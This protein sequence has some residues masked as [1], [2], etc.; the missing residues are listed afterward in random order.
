[1]EE[2]TYL[3]RLSM[4]TPFVKK[5]NTSMRKAITPNEM[6][7]VTLRY[8]VTGR[9]LDDLKFSVQQW[10]RNEKTLRG[11][12]NI[13]GTFRIASESLMGSM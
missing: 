12:L 13:S 1:M 9:T 4:V 5:K 10:G 8:L 2:P 11:N 6:V 7:K 3:E